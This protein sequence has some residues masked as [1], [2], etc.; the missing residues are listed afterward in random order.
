MN[1]KFR[2]SG[3]ALPIFSLP[4]RY[5][6]GDIGP[7]ARRFIDFLADAGFTFWKILPLG[8]TSFGDSPFQSFSSKALNPYFISFDELIDKGLLKK[9]DLTGC[10]WGDNPRF[11]D[12]EKIYKNRFEILK[13]AFKR[14][15][16]GEGDYHR[17]YTIFLR[18]HEFIDY[19]CF[20]VLKEIN[21]G[22]SWN[23]FSGSFNSYSTEGFNRIKKE[24]KEDVE[25]YE[26]T[27]FIF[28]HQW[29]ELRNYASSKGVR[30][31]GEM[32]M[33]ISYDSIDVY[34]HHRNFEL[35]EHD[36]MDYVVG[37]PPDIFY[38]CGQVWGNPL[39][40][41]D[42][43]KRNDYRFLK[44]R[45]NF[46]LSIYDYVTLD[47]F[48]GYLENYLL[49][50]G[51]ENGFNGLWEKG[52]DKDNLKKIFADS[53]RLIAENVDFHSDEIVEVLDD[54]KMKDTRVVEFGYP[55]DGMNFNR[56]DK[57]LY[58]CFSY[59]STHDC[60]PLKAYI[61]K[62]TP[63]QRRDFYEQL[64]S[65]CRNLGVKEVENEEVEE[66]VQ[67]L[68]ELNL[69]SLSSVAILAMQDI[70]F[71]GECARINAPSTVGKNWRYRILEE[72]LT[73]SRAAALRKLNQKYGRM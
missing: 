17:G 8:P 56:P 65:T 57:Y 40:D 7:S 21:S 11:V 50:K 72:D 69:A 64:N 54:L 22:K 18:K 63:L 67:A 2:S 4:S 39:Y 66:A 5:G 61:E 1:N 44:D 70:L 36:G 49:P 60:L 42:Y 46:F 47:H 71:Q 10:S 28:L 53:D 30:I 19:A 68:I 58:P 9:R 15:K 12:Y 13:I 59:S 37:Y 38:S 6:I 34:K 43:M 20:M 27:Q 24:Y 62:L 29:L 41:F 26:W 48:R 32:P 33:Y 23:C 73:A 31:I 55:R 16:R 51:S 25:F 45:L 52:I 14:F 3:V 35:N